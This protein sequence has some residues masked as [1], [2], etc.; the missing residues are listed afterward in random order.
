MTLT[1]S[2]LLLTCVLGI[3]VGQ[4]LFKTSAASV[5]S[6]SLLDLVRGLAVSPLFLLA[7]ALYG[8][9]TVLW[10][11]ILQSVPLTRA[12]PFFALSFIF[13]PVLARVALGEPIATPTAI[14][15]VVI[16]AGVLIVAIGTS[17]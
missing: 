6:P 15:S 10:I 11:W 13:V 3:A 7:L 2:A 12:Y 1:Q 16:V 17:R 9:M 14:G 8:S 5:A 4:L